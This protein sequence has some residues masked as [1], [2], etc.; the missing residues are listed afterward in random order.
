M[1]LR[2]FSAYRRLE[3]SLRIEGES[4]TDLQ[5]EVNRLRGEV[6]TLRDQLHESQNKAQYATECVADFFSQLVTGRKI[7]SHTPDLPEKLTKPAEPTPRAAQQG[8][9]IVQMETAKFYAQEAARM[10]EA[11]KAKSV[12][13]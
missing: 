9:N 11:T 7:Y 1:I 5:D 10:A 12:N 6:S 2:L 13:E 4:R 8:R 3:E